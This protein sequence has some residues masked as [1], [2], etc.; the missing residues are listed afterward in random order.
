MLRLIQRLE[1]WPRPFL[2]VAGVGYLAAVG[3]VDYLTGFEIFFYVFYLVGV[4]FSTW[5]VGRN[6]GYQMAALSVIIWIGGDF[7]AGARYSNSFI[8]IWNSAFLVMFYFIVVWLLAALRS[9]TRNLESRVEQRTLALTREMAERERLEKEILE[10]SER[11]QR[12]IGHDLHDGLCQ[13]LTGTALA[14]QVLTERLE[15]S[16]EPQAADASRIVALVEEGITMAR[17]LAHGLHPVE[18]EAEGI[19]GALRE[20]AANLTKYSRVTCEFVGD[21][22]GGTFDS[23]VAT[24]LYRIAQEAVSNAIR[25]GRPHRILINLMERDDALTLSIEDDGSGLP[26]E[27]TKGPG[28]GLRIMAHRASMIGGA[29]VVEPNPTGGTLVRCSLPVSKATA[30]ESLGRTET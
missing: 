8:P 20:L 19:A 6:F 28:M 15:G 2:V 10:V 16:G 3:L 11:E 27:R 1:Q 4:G 29:F 13:H 25:H 14:A 26:E 9:L 30:H 22:P 18:M 5:F 12:R 23:A 7:V 17:D 24:N 21:S